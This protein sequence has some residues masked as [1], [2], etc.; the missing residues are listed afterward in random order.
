[1]SDSHTNHDFP[2]SLVEIVRSSEDGPRLVT[3]RGHYCSGTNWL[4]SLINSNCGNLEF[5]LELNQPGMELDSDGLYGWKH[6]TMNPKEW[7]LLE[8]HPEHIM[9]V[10]TKD[11]FAWIESFFASKEE[12]YKDNP[13]PSNNY[14]EKVRKQLNDDN[15]I[16]GQADV[17]QL[18][19]FVSHTYGP[20]HPSNGKQRT[21]L[22]YYPPTLRP[23]WDL[24]AENVVKAR[25]KWMANV[26]PG[27][28]K[29]KNVHH[30]R[31]EDLLADPRGTLAALSDAAGLHCA[32]AHDK[33]KE[34]LLSKNQVK[35]GHAVKTDKSNINN[36]FQHAQQTFEQAAYLKAYSKRSIKF[37][38][39]QLDL[40]FEATELGYSY[41]KVKDD[42]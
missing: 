30:V 17:E 36:K 25:N 2:S 6:G 9:V 35:Y 22:G 5:K 40:E 8:S 1:V 31:Y 21:W 12:V 10:L 41:T 27:V 24:T 14:R 29:Y 13:M 34:F 23:Q 32:F 28:K 18:H 33:T 15:T 26:M 11:A 38:L 7:D 39:S 4:R 20:P 3:I 16:V 19:K 37:V 42:L